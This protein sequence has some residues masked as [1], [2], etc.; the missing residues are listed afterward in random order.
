MSASQEDEDPPIR[1]VNLGSAFQW[2]TPNLNLASFLESHLHKCETVLTGY[3][4]NY[5]RSVYAV[6]PKKCL[7]ILTTIKMERTPRQTD[8][9][10]KVQ[11]EEQY[12][13]QGGTSLASECQSGLSDSH[14]RESPAPL[15]QRPQLRKPYPVP[16]TTGRHDL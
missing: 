6:Y 3:L 16:C 13:W 1:P 14:T 15:D 7:S 5:T 11:S 10:T 12:P 9:V 2:S 8:S 4:S